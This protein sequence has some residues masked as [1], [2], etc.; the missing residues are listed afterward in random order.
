MQASPLPVQLAAGGLD[1]ACVSGGAGVAGDRGGAGGVVRGG[2]T[3]SAATAVRPATPA[4]TISAMNAGAS[5][6]TSM[7]TEPR[8]AVPVH[9]LWS[10]VR[11]CRGR[12]A[13]PRSSTPG[14]TD[15]DRPAPC[16][17]PRCVA[18][19]LGPVLSQ[20]T[21]QSPGG[22]Q[23]AGRPLPPRPPSGAWWTRWALTPLWA[24]FSAVERATNQTAAT[25]I[26]AKSSTRISRHH[27]GQ[28]HRVGAPLPGRRPRAAVRRRRGDRRRAP[29]RVRGSAHGGATSAG[30]R[31][32]SGCAFI[33]SLA[34]AQG[35]A[36]DRHRDG[37][38]A[39]DDHS[40]R[41]RAVAALAVAAQLGQARRQ[42]DVQIG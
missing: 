1:A 36:G 25:W 29:A 32:W 19:Q 24:A 2:S 15:R 27:H 31:V 23:E 39:E 6:A 42:R 26:E 34:L 20:P 41:H 10:T 9:R 38:Q 4:S 17:S 18:T 21:S 13:A 35:Q 16:R 7:E 37:D 12:S 3:A 11:P 28:L 22:G 30:S 33:Q 8:S 5:T 14:T 40:G